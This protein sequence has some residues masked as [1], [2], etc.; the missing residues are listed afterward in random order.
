MELHFEIQTDGC[1]IGDMSQCAFCGAW[2][3]PAEAFVVGP[4]FIVGSAQVPQEA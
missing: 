4:V 3:L 1:M 2:I